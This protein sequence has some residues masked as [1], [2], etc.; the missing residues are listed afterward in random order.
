MRIIMAPKKLHVRYE[1][2]IRIS[3]VVSLFYFH[4]DLFVELVTNFFSLKYTDL[5][6]IEL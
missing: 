5:K 1:V 3:Y 4:F 2:H 6:K